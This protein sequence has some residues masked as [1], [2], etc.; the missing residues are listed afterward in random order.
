MAAGRERAA[1]G[2]LVSVAGEG[3]APPRTARAARR[4]I[5]M[6]ASSP[7]CARPRS[8]IWRPVIPSEAR[9][10]GPSEWRRARRRRSLASLGMT[11]QGGRAVTTIGT[12]YLSSTAR[13]AG[14]SATIAR[15]TAARSAVSP[16]RT[17]AEIANTNVA[18]APSIVGLTGVETSGTPVRGPKYPAN[19]PQTIAR[20]TS[21]S[22]HRI[23]ERRRRVGLRVVT[24]NA[25]ADHVA[26]DAPARE[27]RRPQ[28]CCGSRRR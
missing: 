21:P 12:P 5:R 11:G 6:K 7:T 17:P 27:R 3:A 26:H 24:V 15:S 23:H 1:A 19:G 4:I 14:R 10:L 20:S 13:I 28:A 2:T 9:D 16:R 18:A 8:P 25:V 22:G